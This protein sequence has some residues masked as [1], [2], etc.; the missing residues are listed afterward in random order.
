MSFHINS[1]ELSK[2]EQEWRAEYFQ[3]KKPNSQLLRFDNGFL[4]KKR[5][6]EH[7]EEIRNF[8]LRDDDIWIV[9]HPKTGTTWTQEQTCQHCL[10][11]P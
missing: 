6:S 7:L 1:Q 10:T 2:D 8:E 4:L 11:K 9:S 3:D 5:L